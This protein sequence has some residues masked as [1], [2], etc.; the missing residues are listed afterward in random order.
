MLI[1]G[2]GI[3]FNG[4]PPT[5]RSRV[6]HLEFGDHGLLE[7]EAGALPEQ[8]SLGQVPLVERLE[9]VLPLQVPGFAVRAADRMRCMYLSST[10]RETGRGVT[11]RKL[12]TETQQN[13]A[14]NNTADTRGNRNNNTARRPSTQ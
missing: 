7:V 3:A 12:C 8:Q 1:L 2:L 4:N 10:N 13:G 6:S 9:D 11:T 14:K 5:K